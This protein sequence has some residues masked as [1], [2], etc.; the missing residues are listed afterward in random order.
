MLGIEPSEIERAGAARAGDGGLGAARDRREHCG[1]EGDGE[2][3][4]EDKTAASSGTS[5]QKIGRRKQVRRRASAHG[6][7]GDRNW[8]V[9]S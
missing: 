4:G 2:G 6:D 9:C 5:K 7:S 1:A 3:R 8:R